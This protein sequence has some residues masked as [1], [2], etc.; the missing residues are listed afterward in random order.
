MNIKNNIE[1]KE[2]INEER[3]FLSMPNNMLLGYLEFV[4]AKP[5]ISP[6]LHGLLGEKM[7]HVRGMLM[8]DI[9]R[10]IANRN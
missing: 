7:E 10:E 1:F 4:K 8:T 2:L 3:P 9:V 6:E 5:Q